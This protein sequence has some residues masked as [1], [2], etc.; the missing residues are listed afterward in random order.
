MTGMTASPNTIVGPS[1]S[2]TF[3]LSIRNLALVLIAVASD[4]PGIKAS[5]IVAVSPFRCGFDTQKAPIDFQDD[6]RMKTIKLHNPLHHGP[7]RCLYLCLTI[8]QLATEGQPSAYPRV[9]IRVMSFWRPGIQLYRNRLYARGSE[10]QLPASIYPHAGRHCRP[11]N[12]EALW[13]SI[14]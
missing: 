6:C 3:L 1:T 8:A 12:L 13:Q 4:L 14:H 5:P 2:A 10:L 7:L 9:F 11:P